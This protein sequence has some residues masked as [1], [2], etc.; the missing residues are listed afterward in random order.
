MHCMVLRAC[1]KLTRKAIKLERT[2]ITVIDD[3]VR[4]RLKE[5]TSCSFVF[6]NYDYN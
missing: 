1:M 2:D 6:L 4:K 5:L 3:G